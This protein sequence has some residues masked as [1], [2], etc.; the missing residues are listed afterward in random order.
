M[1]IQPLLISAISVVTA[2]GSGVGPTLAAL[3]SGASGLRPCDFA[4]ANLNTWIGRVEG[5]EDEPI[6]GKLAPFDCRNNRLALKGLMQDG[7][8]ARASAARARYGADRIGVFVGTSTSGIQQTEAAY[9]RRNPATG[10]LPAGF[11]Y[12][13]THD[14]FS[15]ADLTRRYLALEGPASAI[16]TACSSSAKAFASAYRHIRA[17]L[18]DAAVVGGVDSLCL[19]TLY[20]FNSLELTSSSP[21][22]PWDIRRDGISIGEAAGFVLLE[23]VRCGIG[24]IELLGY[25]ES[26]DAHHISTPHPEGAG[27][28]LAM[29]RALQSAAL[30]PEQ[31]DYIC[32]HGTA[33]RNN[34]AAEDKAVQRVFGT[35]L[36]CTS[37][38]GYTGHTLGAAGITGVLFTCLS[39]RDG[40][41]PATVNSERP[42]PSLGACIVRDRREL[43]IKLAMCNAF[44]FGGSNCSLVLGRVQR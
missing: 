23:P 15:A 43:T 32:L 39:L 31:V 35:D 13:Y 6:Q 10:A 25:G 27:A 41:I 26:S 8:V 16:A 42:D 44:G 14:L 36:P 38:K 19:T 7:F 4:D 5:L 40:F 24:E 37:I 34:D 1:P 21:C 3:R 17:G 30:R 29:E 28:A 12:R 20:G 22:R 2:L 9:R 11:R 33:T 18:C